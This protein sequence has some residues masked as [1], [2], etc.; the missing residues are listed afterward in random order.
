MFLLLTLTDAVPAANAVATASTTIAVVITIAIAT[1]DV[2]AANTTLDVAFTNT[3]ATADTITT[4]LGASFVI[5]KH[6][7]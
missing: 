2:T 6:Q 4:V 7:D 5:A 1:N 3:N